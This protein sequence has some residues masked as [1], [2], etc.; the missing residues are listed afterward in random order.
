MQHVMNWQDSH[1]QLLERILSSDNMHRAWKQV[2]GNKGAPG[3][4]LGH[5]DR[6]GPADSTGNRAGPDR[7]LRPGFFGA[8]LRI[9]AG[10]V[11]PRCRLSGAGI[12]QAVVHHCRGHGP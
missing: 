6:S 7:D 9:Q 4:V 8:Q 5:P 2:K 1:E 3:P 12:S 10:A 11:C